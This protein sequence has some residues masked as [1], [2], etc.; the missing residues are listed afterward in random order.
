MNRTEFKSDLTKIGSLSYIL[1]ILC[2]LYILCIK[3][4]KLDICIL[5]KRNYIYNN[6]MN[7][8]K[9]K[10]ITIKCIQLFNKRIIQNG[11]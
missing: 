11:Y 5:S 3:Q 9:I 1:C 2:K 8:K 6:I 7:T 4:K 10:Y